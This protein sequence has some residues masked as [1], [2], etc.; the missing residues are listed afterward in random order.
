MRS[1]NPNWLDG[2]ENKIHGK[3][4]VDETVISNLSAQFLI[5]E[6]SKAKRPFKVYNLGAGVK[7]IT[8]E[9]D[10]CPCCKKVLEPKA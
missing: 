6:L 5:S 10:V 3:L 2:M 7:R 1:L 4:P 8:T 9:T